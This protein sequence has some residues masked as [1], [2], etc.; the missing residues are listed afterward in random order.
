VKFVVDAQLPPA[1]AR[2]LSE[3]GYEA[4]HVADVGLL[5]ASDRE[6]WD[7]AKEQEAVIISKDEDFAERAL[8]AKEAPRVVWLRIGNSSKQALLLWF[9]NLL[10]E[11]ISK[12]EAG[13]KL[14]EII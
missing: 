14:I 10:P 1:L 12:L 8:M 4:E 3:E 6:I 7:Y 9:R 5:A 13:E 2:F 11:I